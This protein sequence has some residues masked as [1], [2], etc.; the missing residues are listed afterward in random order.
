M[1]R[2]C[3]E[4]ASLCKGS[5]AAT[6]CSTEDR[7]THSAGPRAI[8]AR[9]LGMGQLSKRVTTKSTEADSR[10]IVVVWRTPVEQESVSMHAYIGYLAQVKGQRTRAFS[11]AI[12]TWVS[13]FISFPSVIGRLLPR[14]PRYI[15][16]IHLMDTYLSFCYRNCPH[17]S[18]I[19]CHRFSGIISFPPTALSLS[20]L[21]LAEC[22]S[23]ST[24]AQFSTALCSTVLYHSNPCK[25]PIL[26]SDFLLIAVEREPVF[27][28]SAILCQLR[29]TV[30]F[31]CTVAV[32]TYLNILRFLLLPN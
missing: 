26:R 11:K 29:R 17:I 1:V 16:Q 24:L 4:D 32:T 8:R 20:S 3:E 30:F 2:D 27:I 13:P 10:P 9:F 6:G 23:T 19:L 28:F 5:G 7:V 25:Q 21:P 15:L 18:T 22:E 14:V 31:H 12:Q